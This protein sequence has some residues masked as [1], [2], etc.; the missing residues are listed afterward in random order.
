M[1][2]RAGVLGTCLGKVKGAGEDSDEL[3]CGPEGTQGESPCPSPWM[4]S[5]VVDLDGNSQNEFLLE[6]KNAPSEVSLLL[7]NVHKALPCLKES[8]RR[9]S[10]S[11]AAQSKTVDLSCAPAGGRCAGVACGRGGA[12]ARGWPGGGPRASDSHRCR[13]GEPWG[14]GLPCLQKW[15]EVEI[16]EEE[17]PSALLEGRGSESELSCLHF[18]L[19]T[20]LR[21][22]P[23]VFLNEETECV[24]LGHSN[25]AFS[26]QT[27]YKKT[28]SPVKS[29]SADLQI[30]LGSLAL[31]ALEV[32]NPLCHS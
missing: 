5:P 13:K 12:L 19:S 20:L 1:R 14:S 18:V 10:T 4:R 32:A 27:E 28:L 22:R 7:H 11:T 21:A 26:E 31:P 15:S 17:S 23:E 29:T 30:T 24:F 2:D 16:S 9:S 25:P 6:V 8:L 3:L